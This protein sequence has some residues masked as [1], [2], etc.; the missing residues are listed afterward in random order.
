[1]TATALPAS[2]QALHAPARPGAAGEHL[3]AHVSA[4]HASQV[5]ARER[6]ASQVRAGVHLSGQPDADVSTRTTI[7]K[8]A[9]HA[10]TSTKHQHADKGV[11]GPPTRPSTATGTYCRSLSA[12]VWKFG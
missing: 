2:T 11:S 3:H 12:R 8:R 7:A 4:S 5:D 1:M 9:R 6:V 10:P